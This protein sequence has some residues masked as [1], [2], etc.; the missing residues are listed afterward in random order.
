MRSKSL[1]PLKRLLDSVIVAK[2]RR[3]IHSLPSEMSSIKAI[4]KDKILMKII[5]TSVKTHELI[6]RKERA[7]RYH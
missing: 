6:L 4:I 1:N 5:R 3:A 7:P 2:T